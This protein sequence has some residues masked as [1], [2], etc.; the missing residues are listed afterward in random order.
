VGEI[1]PVTN[2]PIRFAW[3]R[4]KKS[5]LRCGVIVPVYDDPLSTDAHSVVEGSR[6]AI[7]AARKLLGGEGGT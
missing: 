3:P 7:A 4:Y 2:I 6:D 5:E 1:W